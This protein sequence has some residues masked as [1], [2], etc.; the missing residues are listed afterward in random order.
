M[1]KKVKALAA[2]MLIAAAILFAGCTPEE[3]NDANNN[4][5]NN[6]GGNQTTT[7]VPKVKTSDIFDITDTHAYGRGEVVSEGES[8]VIERGLCW[9]TSI[10]PTLNDSHAQDTM[11]QEVFT[12]ML[13]DLL[14][15][16]TYYVRAYAVNNEGVGYGGQV[17]FTTLDTPEPP[18]EASLI[19]VWGVE[20]ID[21]YCT[22][23]YGNPIANTLQTYYYPIGD[24][25]NGIEM[26][27]REDLT[28]EAIDH[29]LDS[30]RVTTFI[31]SYDEYDSILYLTV[32]TPSYHAYQMSVPV[33]SDDSFVYVNEYVDN[34][35]EKAYMKRLSYFPDKSRS[36]QTVNSNKPFA[37]G[38]LFKINQ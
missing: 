8:S 18:A 32:Q 14:P 16:T 21:Y 27:F 37:K 25:D 1:N 3:S 4:W 2:V 30:L 23:Y 11:G 10:K 7:A 24:P 19:G 9:S 20:Q 13:D 12:C 36:T 31:Y 26:V 22:D 38:P 35:V 15:A 28:G 5:M 33:L 29:S 34:Y 6:G 17:S